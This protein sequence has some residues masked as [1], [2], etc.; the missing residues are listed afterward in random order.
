MSRLRFFFPFSLFGLQTIWLLIFFIFWVKLYSMEAS[1]SSEN[2]K[3]GFDVRVLHKLIAWMNNV[4]FNIM[5]ELIRR[6]IDPS[7]ILLYFSSHSLLWLE[8]SEKKNI[9]RQNSI[10]TFQL[11]ILLLDVVG[12]FFHFILTC[13]KW[14]WDDS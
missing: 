3:F 5:N 4:S 12:F 13:V 9:R 6:S 2:E 14:Q 11:Y 10:F 1:V 7:N 8:R